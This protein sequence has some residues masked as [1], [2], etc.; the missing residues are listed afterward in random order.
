[1]NINLKNKTLKHKHAKI[2]NFCCVKIGDF[3]SVLGPQMRSIWDIGNR[4]FSIAP[5][6]IAYKHCQNSKNFD[7]SKIE[8][9]RMLRVCGPKVLRTLRDF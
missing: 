8:D 1:M 2:E 5:K 6:I 9:F 3:D 4:R 7:A